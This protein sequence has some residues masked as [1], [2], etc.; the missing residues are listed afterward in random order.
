MP[1]GSLFSVIVIDILAAE[2]D[3]CRARTQDILS[4]K[5]HLL[6]ADVVTE[7]LTDGRLPDA[8]SDA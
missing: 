4:F 5:R 6:P 7:V 2:L 1:P 8:K 3:V